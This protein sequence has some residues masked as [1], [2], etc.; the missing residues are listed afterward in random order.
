MKIS[1]LLNE[2]QQL[3]EITRPAGRYSAELVLKQAGYKKLGDGAFA[4]VYGKAGSQHVLK[5][6]NS[7]DNA[8]REFVKLANSKPNPHFPVFRGKM[9]RVTD[10]YYA[11]R[12]E[13]LTPVPD[14][15]ATEYVG[16]ILTDYVRLQQGQR[17]YEISEEEVNSEMRKLEKEQPGISE[18][19]KLIASGI[20]KSRTI[21]IHNENYMMR[22]PVLV[23]TDPVAFG[24]A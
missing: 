18:A 11:I 15:R 16:D 3:D 19:C 14:N 6:F 2:D 20:S 7:T 5:L 24:P 1:E 13:W 17:P 9:M 8:Y 4:A 10:K 23:I 22:G 12:M 21:D